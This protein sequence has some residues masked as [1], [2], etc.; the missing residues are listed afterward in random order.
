[1]SSRFG[2]GPY[3]FKEMSLKPREWPFVLRNGFFQGLEDSE[4][5]GLGPLRFET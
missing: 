2:D 3:F 1:M 5:K 4:L